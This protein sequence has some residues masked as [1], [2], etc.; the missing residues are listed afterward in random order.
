MLFRCVFVYEGVCDGGDGGT[1][2]RLYVVRCGTDAARCVPRARRTPRG[3]PLVPRA[4][5][6]AFFGV[7]R[8]REFADLLR[9]RAP[10]GRKF[11]KY[12][13]D[14]AYPNPYT[15]GRA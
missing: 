4:G 15:I 1:G 11:A 10:R 12:A 14:R 9:R 6:L 7:A 5:A 2:V 8:A 13:S 3:T